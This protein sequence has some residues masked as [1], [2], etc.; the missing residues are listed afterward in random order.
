M[1]FTTDYANTI[2]TS[3]FS[4]A[5]IA[6]TTASPSASSTGSN[7]SEPSGNGYA[8]AQA[9]QGS[10]SASARTIKNTKYVYYPEATG[11]W[12]TITHM[13]VCSAETG[14][15]L[16]YYG[17]LNS[18]VSVSANTVPLFKPQTIQI[19]LDAD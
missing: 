11:S 6:L 14:G 15:Q 5:Y 18:S 1:G 16:R 4:G 17:A 13:C 19:S 10:F 2:L 12:G 3:L 9:S 7:L 8:R